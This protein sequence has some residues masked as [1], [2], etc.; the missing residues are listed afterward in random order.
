MK[1]ERQGLGTVEIKL[2]EKHQRFVHFLLSTSLQNM[3]PPSWILKAE[4][5]LGENEIST[6]GVVDYDRLSSPTHSLPTFLAARQTIAVYNVNMCSLIRH[7]HCI[8]RNATARCYTVLMP[9]HGK[10]CDCV[11]DPIFS[12]VTN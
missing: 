12:S 5:G 8:Y 9:W 2:K 3:W 11:D 4:E 1:D 6:K 7:L 10:L